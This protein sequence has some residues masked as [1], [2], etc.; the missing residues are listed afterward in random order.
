MRFRHIPAT[1]TAI[2]GVAATMGVVPSPEAA[3]TPADPGIAGVVSTAGPDRSWDVRA[4]ITGT[5]T[6][7]ATR[8]ERPAPTG[9]DTSGSDPRSNPDPMRRST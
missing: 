6:A 7:S 4:W 2:I 3:A 8:P 5:G 1:L 9:P